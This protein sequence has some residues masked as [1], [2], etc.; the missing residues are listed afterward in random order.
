MLELTTLNV[1][2]AT[3]NGLSAIAA[4]PVKKPDLRFVCV[5]LGIVSLSL[6][7]Q[8]ISLDASSGDRCADRHEWEDAS[9]GSSL[10]S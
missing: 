7:S 4:E 8:S 1:Y 2:T 3:D 5:R 9:S 10:D 6:A